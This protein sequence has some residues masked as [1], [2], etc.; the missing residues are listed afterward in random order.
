M[1]VGFMAKCVFLM[2][3]DVLWNLVVVI[4]RSI[5]ELIIDKLSINGCYRKL[6]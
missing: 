5:G 1:V 6:E 4:P 3:R 2:Y